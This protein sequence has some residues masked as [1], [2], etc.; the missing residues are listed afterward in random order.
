[1][2]W[3]Q[4]RLHG[5]TNTEIH[6]GHL[7]VR[8]ITSDW[9][10][11]RR[12][13][14]IFYLCVFSLWNVNQK[15]RSVCCSQFVQQHCAFISLVWKSESEQEENRTFLKTLIYRMPFYFWALSCLHL[16]SQCF[17]Y[18]SHP[19]PLYLFTHPSCF[20]FLP[21]SS[22]PRCLSHPLISLPP[23]RLSS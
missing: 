7:R 12:S 6:S 13:E 18:R 9:D 17:L 4:C 8:T 3:L 15:L 22:L 23:Q 2:T 20:P 11:S 1:M 14:V 21:P 19:L 5:G 16:N 10:K